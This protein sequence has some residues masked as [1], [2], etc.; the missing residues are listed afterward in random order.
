MPAGA[1]P[2]RRAHAGAP[3]AL[4]AAALFH[5]RC[6]REGESTDERKLNMAMSLFAY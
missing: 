3:G 5:V 4:P 1:C 6:V 2:V